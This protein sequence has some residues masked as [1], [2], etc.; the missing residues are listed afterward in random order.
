MGLI[1][2]KDMSEY[3]PSLHLSII[4]TR[5][6]ENKHS[7]DLMT[8]AVENVMCTLHFSNCEWLNDKNLKNYHTKCMNLETY[9]QTQ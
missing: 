6:K 3:S 1:Q 4:N 2:I 7:Y 5:F 9:S 8:E